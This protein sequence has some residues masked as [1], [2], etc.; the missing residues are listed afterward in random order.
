MKTYVEI[1]IYSLLPS[2]M[3]FFTFKILWV[4]GVETKRD[5]NPGIQL[6]SGDASGQIIHWDITTAMVLATLQDGN[7]PVLGIIFVCQFIL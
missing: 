2:H 5:G 1:S 7:K 4:S 3:N 6:V